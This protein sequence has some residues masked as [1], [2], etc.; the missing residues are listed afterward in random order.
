MRDGHLPE[1]S[2]SDRVRDG[3]LRVRCAVQDL[4][5]ERC[6]YGRVIRAA[7]EEWGVSMRDLAR[8]AG[9]S[10]ATIQRLQNGAWTPTKET[11][12]KIEKAFRTF[13]AGG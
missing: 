7:R 12:D 10:V 2:V 3:Y 4:E 6:A 5:E 9:L 13:E 8:A 11:A 1:V